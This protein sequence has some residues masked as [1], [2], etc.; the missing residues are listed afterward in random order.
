MIHIVLYQ[1]EIPQNTGNII[2]TCMAIN[3][4]L[5]LIKPLGFSLDEKSLK[6]AGM[7]YINDVELEVYESVEE[8][9]QKNEDADIYYVTRYASR[10]HSSFDLSKVTKDYYFMFGKE[11]SGIP[12]ELLRGNKDKLMRIPMSMNARSLNLS[13]SVAI[14]AYEACRQQEYFDLST[15]EA[16]KGEDFLESEIK[17]D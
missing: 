7:D 4:T 6:R 17:D 8:F 14:V 5:H 3:A 12:H 16:I 9:Y 2:R 11:S 15:F 1:P 10:P 13:N